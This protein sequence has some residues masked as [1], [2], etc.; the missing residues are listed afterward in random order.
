M[1]LAKTMTPDKDIVICLSG[2][3][4]KGTLH[5]PLRCLQFFLDVQSVA[6]ELP[7]LGPEI[8]WDLRF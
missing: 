3:G 2:R 6:E 1:E 5:S 8:G 4:D 7:R